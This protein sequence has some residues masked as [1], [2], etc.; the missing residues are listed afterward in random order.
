MVFGDSFI[1]DNLYCKGLT[2]ATNYTNGHYAEIG[3]GGVVVRF[4][5]AHT[6]G[7][8]FAPSA[9]DFHTFKFV[10]T[11]SSF[12][13]SLDGGEASD[14]SGFTLPVGRISFVKNGTY[15]IDIASFSIKAL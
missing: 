12:T 9:T 2:N 3:G 11:S 10:K 13:V 5:G 7:G 1:G 6:A 8:A 4:D 15:P 14:I